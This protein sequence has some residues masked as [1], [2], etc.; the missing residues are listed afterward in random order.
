MNRSEASYL[1]FRKEQ[2]ELTAE[3]KE[4][5]SHLDLNFKNFLKP[6]PKLK[7]KKA[8]L[9]AE[10]ERLSAQRLLAAKIDRLESDAAKKGEELQAAAEETEAARRSLALLEA[11]SRD[12]AAWKL[13]QDLEDGLPCPVC[14]ALSHPE[15]ART[16]TNAPTKA[17]L[18][19]AG[20]IVEETGRKYERIFRENAALSASCE[21]QKKQM[22]ILKEKKREAAYTEEDIERELPGIEA[23]LRECV[24]AESRQTELERDLKIVEDRLAAVRPGLETALKSRDAAA[25]SVSALSGSIQ[26]LSSAVPEELRSY[27]KLSALIAERK[28]SVQA[29]SDTMEHIRKSSE[30]ARNRLASAQAHLDA[31]SEAKKTADSEFETVA[32]DYEAKLLQAGF[33]ADDDVQALSLDEK[34]REAIADQVQAFDRERYAVEEKVNLLK[35][36]LENIERPDMEALETAL[37]VKREELDAAVLQT[38]GLQTRVKALEDCVG[39][40]ESIRVRSSLAEDKYS[41][42]SR[43]CRLAGG[44]NPQKTPIHQ[45]VLGIM[46]EDILACANQRLRILSRGRYSLI[47][48]EEPARGGGAKGLELS[49]NDAWQGGIR[50][51]ST[52]SGG[53]MFLAS[54]SLAF[55]LSD[56]A[57]S[58]AGG[59]RLDSIFIDE[60]FGSLDSETLD[61][62]MTALQMLQNG[63]SERLIGIISHVDEL[64]ERIPARIEVKPGSAGTGIRIKTL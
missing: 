14:G 13:S 40:L 41:L 26:E 56:M 19:A 51:V 50:G 61:T 20:R 16:A 29:D 27:S 8:V 54:L 48:S 58:Y 6:A 64:K 35:M 23:G 30:T 45:F 42:Y 59:I 28:C 62:A 18:E 12:A 15:P 21:E 44:E 63:D 2:E 25:L 36:E 3:I 43:I 7:E 60:G 53:E 33:S 31:A 52:L 34:G 1:A 10:K 39:Q 46:L 55:G 49:V 4:I 47:R 24:A 17:Q 32:V 37:R 9:E 57:Q 11:I 22:K 38:G 5:Q